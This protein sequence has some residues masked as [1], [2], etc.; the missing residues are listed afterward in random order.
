[1]THR[2]TVDIKVKSW[3]DI[4]CKHWRVYKAAADEAKLCT[5]AAL[6]RAKIPKLTKLPVAIHFH[7]RWKRKGRR[8]ID[9]LYCKAILDQMVKSK[10][11]PDD[12]LNCVLSVTFT[13]ELEADRDELLV[14]IESTF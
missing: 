12:N 13:G 3:N 4:A 7:A 2:F 8:D 9:A 10:I 11:L 1:M 6:N 5:V 14:R